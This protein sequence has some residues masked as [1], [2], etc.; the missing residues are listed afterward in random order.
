MTRIPKNSLLKR[1]FEE[2]TEIVRHVH[3]IVRH[4]P[5]LP[6][7]FVFYIKSICAFCEDCQNEL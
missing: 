3:S 7:N 4:A 6:T 5:S 2:K 1:H